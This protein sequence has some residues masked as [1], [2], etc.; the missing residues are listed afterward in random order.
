MEI[1]IWKPV[2]GFEGSYD[3]SNLGR[4]KS[5]ERI[6]TQSNGKTLRVRERIRVIGFGNAKGAYENI[7]LGKGGVFKTFYVHHLVLTAFV[8]P[9]PDGKEGCHGDG[10]KRN[11]RLS[12]LRWDTRKANHADKNIHNTQTCGMRHPKA[13]L[14]DDLVFQIRARRASGANLHELAEE[15]QQ[16]SRMTVYRAATGRSWSHLKKGE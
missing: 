1:E 13:K 12:N 3:I 6:I 15:F 5:I 14:T 4:I 9:M 7:R 10:N 16:V 11:N 2:V 8:C